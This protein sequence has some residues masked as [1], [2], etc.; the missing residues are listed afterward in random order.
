MWFTLEAVWDSLQPARF[1][2]PWD[3]PGKNTRV[4]SH[5]LLQGI[6]QDQGSES[7]LLHWQEGSLPLSH[8]RS[9]MEINFLK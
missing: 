6:L 4:G 1:P 5:F 8:K 9:P 2:C 7:H 3:F